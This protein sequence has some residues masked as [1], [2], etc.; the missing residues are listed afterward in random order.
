MDRERA[1]RIMCQHNISAD[2]LLLLELILAAQDGDTDAVGLIRDF[3]SQVYVEAVL[4]DLYDNGH[5]T[6][7]SPTNTL[8]PMKIKVNSTLKKQLYKEFLQMGQELWDAYP[9][10][11]D[12]D[13]KSVWLKSV[14]RHY[15]SLDEA[16]MAYA[17]AI[18]NSPTKHEEIVGLVRW[19][20]ENN[21]INYALS[22]FIIDQRWNELA[23]RRKGDTGGINYDAT[24]ML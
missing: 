23:S 8:D 15:D 10:F 4:Q 14:S 3:N 5:L 21:L 20:M 6:K 11:C 13:G 24:E 9:E 1:V 16:Y 22:T 18:H 12:I 19:G 17:R 7:S 2:E